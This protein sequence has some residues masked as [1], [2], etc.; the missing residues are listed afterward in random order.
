MLIS[1]LYRTN[2]SL[3]DLGYEILQQWYKQT[4]EQKHSQIRWLANQLREGVGGKTIAVELARRL[5]VTIS[6]SFPPPQPPS[7][8]RSRSRRT[9]KT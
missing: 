7:G 9:A 1:Q 3:N 8:R 4:N 2:P 5:G 6:E